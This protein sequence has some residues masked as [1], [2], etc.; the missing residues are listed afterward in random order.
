MSLAAGTRLGPYESIS[1]IGAGAM[2]VV[3]K[4]RDTRLGRDVAVKVL[5]PVFARDPDRLSRFEREARAVAAINHP[6][7]LS[8][9]DIG[10]ADIVDTEQGPVRATYMITELLDGDTLRARLA[11]GPLAPRKS[12]DVAMQIARGLAAAH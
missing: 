6:N 1:T 8:V 10:G 9:H 2:G 11:Q 7:I 5:P 3:Y 4:A 12:A